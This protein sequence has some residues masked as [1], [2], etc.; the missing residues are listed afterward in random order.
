VPDPLAAVWESELVPMLETDPSLKP[1]TLLHYLMRTYPERFPGQAIR[2]TLERRMRAWTALH[3]PRRDV[4][5]RQRQEPGR[6]ALADL[7]LRVDFVSTDADQLG[8][9]IAGAPLRHRLYHF[10]L[11]YSGWQF[12][13]VVLGG[14]SFTA[15]AESLQ[16]A[17]W[18]LGG[19]PDEHRTDSLSAAFKN[20]DR[21]Q[22]ADLTARYKQLCAHYRLRA[23]RNNPGGHAVGAAGARRTR[24]APSRR[25][26]ATSTRSRRLQAPRM[27]WSRR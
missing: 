6:P 12:A 18:E 17:L 5:F 20:L 7:T 22:Q 14:E 16:A 8:V 19:V 24:T 25:T 26:T 4:I 21:D 9:T 1:V 3:G 23:S 27:P 2:H 13:R 10:V 15:L 11:P